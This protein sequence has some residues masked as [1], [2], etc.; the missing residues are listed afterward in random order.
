MSAIRNEALYREYVCG[1]L[2]PS[3]RSIAAKVPA[4]GVGA[5]QR[6]AGQPPSRARDVSP[7]WIGEGTCPAI[8]P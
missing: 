2:L 8:S 6:L 3:E 7:S 1:H 5:R 4:I